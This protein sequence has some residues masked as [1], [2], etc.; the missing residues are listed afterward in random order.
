MSFHT[1]MTAEQWV[2][3]SKKQMQREIQ[4]L[5]GLANFYNSEADRLEGK[6]KKKY[7]PH[8]SDRFD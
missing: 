1:N 7:D 4:R 6:P 5:R 3:E 8:F 2:E